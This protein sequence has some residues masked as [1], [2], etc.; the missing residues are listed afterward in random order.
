MSYYYGG[1]RPYI[2]FGPSLTRAVKS[3]ILI[4]AGVF[5]LQLI[6]K[7]SDLE[8]G[9]THFFG[10]VPVL[11]SEKSMLWQFFT[12]MFLH[13]GL[14]H[15][16]FN[17]LTLW[18]FGS[19]LERE[20][21]RKEFLRY[22]FITGVGAGILYYFSAMRSAIPAIGAS[23]AIFGVLVAYALTFPER[24]I[25][26]FLFFILPVTMKAR[27]LILFFGG[28]QLLA[29]LHYGRT[30]GIA[31]FAHLGGMLVGYLYLRGWRRTGYGLS[32]WTAD[33]RFRLSQSLI[34]RRAKRRE[35]LEEDVDSILDKISREGMRSLTRRERR[36]LQ[37]KSM[38]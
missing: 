23:G 36:I 38:R 5:L 24:R 21:G 17:M 33:L 26:L 22:Y 3:L 28:L 19:D 25:T 35:D 34:R 10:L 1:E 8:R 29:L 15:I 7:F 11:V 2:R 30:S 13:G 4:N 27:H 18:M 20:W 32:G 6:L 12:Y 14:F 9:F 37:R 31:H 16:L